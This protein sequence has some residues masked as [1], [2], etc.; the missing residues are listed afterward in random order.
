MSLGTLA[1][2]KVGYARTDALPGIAY[3]M[4]YSD[5]GCS[6]LCSFCSQSFAF[7]T[8]KD[9]LSRVIWPEM[10]LS[11]FI[12]LLRSSNIQRVCLQTIIKKGFIEEAHH[13]VRALSRTGAK[14]SLS[15]TPI[16]SA[17]LVSF[18]KEGVDYL[19]VGLDS[20][21]KHTMEKILKPYGWELYWTFI[22]E[23]VKIFGRRKVVTHLI[24]GVGE[25]PID[26]LD[27]ITRLR[28]EGSEVSLF[29][30]TPL[31]GSLMERLKRPLMRYYRFIQLATYLIM[32]GY[33][34]KEFV[35]MRKGR[36]Y[37]RKKYVENEEVLYS[38]LMTR[39]CPGC[40]RPFY[41]ES[42]REEPYNFPSKAIIED[43]KTVLR[44]ELNDI[45]ID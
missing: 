13:I 42:P 16:P 14:V 4:Q 28:D 27:T 33:E 40:N 3:I 18:K 37:I 45:F 22:S 21:S 38:A 30:F 43:W 19:G 44:T 32:K 2:L 23:G 1:T 25:S 11:V 17:E 39:G 26:L 7:N 34:W 20:A 9:T 29:S 41:N 15:I 6:A 10:E 12:D 35:T 5:V 31:K 24:V 8:R 36:L